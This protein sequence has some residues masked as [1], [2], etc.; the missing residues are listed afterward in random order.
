MK[1]NWKIALLKILFWFSAEILLNLVGL[2][3]IADCSEFVFSHHPEIF[4][5]KA[6]YI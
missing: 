3:N 1:S 2:D 6:L 4:K 5:T